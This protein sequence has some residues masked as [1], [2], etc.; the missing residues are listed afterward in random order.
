MK[1]VDVE[2]PSAASSLA[3]TDPESAL[4]DLSS[5]LLSS[6]GA[7]ARQRGTSSSI[8]PLTAIPME[9]VRHHKIDENS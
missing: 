8:V 9:D 7:V 4:A 1:T 5:Q 6:E 2:T 3:S